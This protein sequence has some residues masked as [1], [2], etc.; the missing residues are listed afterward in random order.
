[1]NHWISPEYHVWK[2]ESE[3]IM[4]IWYVLQFQNLLADI[5]EFKNPQD[6]LDRENVIWR[7]HSLYNPYFN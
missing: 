4:N 3:D 7:R 2:D 6:N 1:M 5:P